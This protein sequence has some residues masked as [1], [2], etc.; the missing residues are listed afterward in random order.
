MKIEGNPSIRR[1]LSEKSCFVLINILNKCNNKNLTA[2]NIAREIN[3][4]ITNPIFM[5]LINYLK[6]IE[7][8]EEIET[9]GNNKLLSIDKESL[10]DFIDEQNI[11]QFWAE[12]FFRKYH[13]FNW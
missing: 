8:I 10:S 11:T 4:K 3:T 9:I 5:N 2:S 12:E 7:I 1:D 13:K 6:E